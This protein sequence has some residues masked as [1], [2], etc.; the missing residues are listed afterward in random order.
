MIP[1]LTALENVILGIEA[2]IQDKNEQRSRAEKYLNLVGLS[3]KMHNIPQ[4]LSA[5]EQQRV[6]IARALVKNA[7]IL[8][9]DEATSALDAVSES[10]IKEAIMDLH[11]CITQILIAHRLSTIK[12]ADKIVVI[13][14]GI[15]VEEGTL[16]E[17]LAKR[18][19]FH[20]YWEEQKF[21]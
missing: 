16:E 21:Y 20:V 6:A 12:H 18:A 1:T 9:M 13:E 4:E 2:V 3:E 5:G 15:L 14:N 19:K 10:R 11:G 8:V 17:L 7:P